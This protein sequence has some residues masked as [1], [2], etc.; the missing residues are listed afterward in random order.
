MQVKTLPARRGWAWVV[1]GFALWRRNP[2][3][4]TFLVMGYT[5]SQ[6]VLFIVPYVGQI[7]MALTVPALSLGVYNGCKAVAAGRKVGPDVLFS[8]FRQNLPELVKI[9]GINFV[10]TLLL[11]GL[12]ILIDPDMGD[13]IMDA[14]GGKADFGELVSADPSFVLAL[15]LVSVGS[16]P[17]VMA[18]WFAPLLAGWGKVPAA[19]ALFFSFVA[20]LRNWRAFLVYGLCLLIVAQAVSLI[21]VIAGLIAPFAAALVALS[22]PVVFMPVIFASMYTNAIDVFGQIT[23][24]EQA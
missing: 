3:L 22:F 7:I 20:C 8:G 24:D 11:M 16:T 9:G 19:K 1:D 10:S 13:K 5:L 17:L 15:L 4:I 18:Y 2:A 14:L 23:P 21:T 6:L 12:S